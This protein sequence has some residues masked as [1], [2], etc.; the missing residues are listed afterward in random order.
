MRVSIGAL[1][2]TRNGGHLH[3]R[4]GT[5]TIHI[6]P[7]TTGLPALIERRDKINRALL[8]SLTLDDRHHADL[9]RRGLDDSEIEKH[10]FRSMPDR[11][12]ADS[13]ASR[14]GWEYDGLV[15]IPGF[16]FGAGEWRMVAGDWWAR[17]PRPGDGSGRE[18][19]GF[20]DSPRPGRPALCMALIGQPAETKT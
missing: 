4:D 1:K 17:G 6:Q 5:Q 8:A 19:R 20:P 7:V 12:T 11:T 9:R 16:Y 14:L 3:L 10:L 13:I 18:D 2:T 15:G